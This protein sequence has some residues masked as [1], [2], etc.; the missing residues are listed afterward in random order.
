M[1]D[2]KMTRSALCGQLVSVSKFLLWA[3][4]AT[5]SVLAQSTTDHEAQLLQ[6]IEAM[7]QQLASTQEQL[8][9]YHRQLDNLEQK[10]VSLQQEL[11]ATQAGALTAATVANLSDAVTKL[12]EEQAA[13]QTEIAVHEQT[14]V[15]TGS[16]FPLK[17]SGLVL[18]NANA[19]DGA[20]NNTTIPAIA[21][22]RT[23]GVSNGSLKASL[24]QTLLGLEGKGPEIWGAQTYGD[25]HVDFFVEQTQT[26]SSSYF[27]PAGIL[28]LRTAGVQIVW[29]QTTIQAGV[30]PL[31]LAPH[32]PTSFLSIAEPAMSW[33]GNLWSWLPQ[34]TVRQSFP[35]SEQKQFSLEGSLL[36]VPDSP[37]NSSPTTSPYGPVSA[38]E[39]SRYPGVALRSAYLW[40][41][42]RKDSIGVGGYWS[43][44]SYGASGHIDGQA[45]TGDWFLSLPAHLSFSGQVYHGAG[46]GGLNN[47][48]YKD[49]VPVAGT[50]E[51]GISYI[52]YH[53]FRD[54]GG[55][56]QLGWN[57]NGRM[58]FNLAFGEDSG[59][60]N[61]LRHSNYYGTYSYTGLVRNQ[62]SLANIIYRPHSSIIFST[63]YRKVNSW[64]IMGRKNQAQV[65][66]LAAGYQF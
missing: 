1:H 41:G 31:I 51:Y 61:Q 49:I 24:S 16:R 3:S 14:K 29:P 9:T 52:R 44:H 5:A 56:T 55:W 32:A 8:N 20:V 30:E 12:Q 11:A 28:R 13:E 47:G 48:A 2:N 10:V 17:I 54:Q 46:L 6:Q 38:A 50:D 65:F 27:S 40:N 62:T 36:D 64:Q 43:P 7:K 57:A 34:L 63:E 58:E 22:S 19:I 35:V 33:S 18:F 60:S 39:H 23:N 26:S 53:A 42:A 25:L 37:I 59:D 45:V 15:E 21:V 4:L 66:G